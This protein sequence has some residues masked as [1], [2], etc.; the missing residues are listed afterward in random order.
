MTTVAQLPKFNLPETISPDYSSAV[1]PDGK[2]P[3]SESGEGNPSALGTLDADGKLNLDQ[4]SET[5]RTL[6]SSVEITGGPVMMG[7]GFRGGVLN[8]L[9]GGVDVLSGAR[10]IT[11][12]ARG[13]TLEKTDKMV[14]GG[15]FE[16]SAKDNDHPLTQMIAHLL[17]SKG[18]NF[19][20]GAQLEIKL[21]G[22]GTDKMRIESITIQTV[23]VIPQVRNTPGSY[24]NFSA[25][26]ST[27]KW[28]FKEDGAVEFKSNNQFRQGTFGV[29]NQSSDEEDEAIEVSTGPIRGLM[30]G[31]VSNEVK[32]PGDLSYDLAAVTQLVDR[33]S[34]G[35]ALGREGQ[36]PYKVL[37][38]FNAA[39]FM[40]A[41]GQALF[42]D[43]QQDGQKPDETTFDG[44]IRVVQAV[45]AFNASLPADV[46]MFGLYWQGNFKIKAI[47]DGIPMIKFFQTGSSEPF[48][49]VS[50][51]ELKD[52]YKKMKSELEDMVNEVMDHPAFNVK[53]APHRTD[54]TRIEEAFEGQDMEQ[55]PHTPPGPP[56]PSSEELNPPGAT[57]R[58]GETQLG[59]PVIPPETKAPRTVPSDD[60]LRPRSTDGT[61]Q[62]DEYED[63]QLGG[64]QN[65][66]DLPPT[67]VEINQETY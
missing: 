18:V 41:L 28:T 67:P 49:E 33:G 37:D 32:D 23:A 22:T 30:Y 10:I 19:E 48:Y 38:V 47:N 58:H 65:P 8:W 29:L 36:N 6:I 46:P 14:I 21:T 15:Y 5:E 27:M 7:V 52:F 34:I 66:L 4:L 31:M 1:T 60:V 11:K 61:R 59:A 55:L 56:V 9:V 64:G 50:V 16:A 20:A 54:E 62:R 25:P 35:D 53:Y 40:G 44:W 13:E 43:G 63:G 12:L 3:P 2:N 39:Q 45:D 57:D 24:R 42:E 51:Q 17:N 26:G